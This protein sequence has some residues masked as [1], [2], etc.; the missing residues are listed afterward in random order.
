MKPRLAT[1]AEDPEAGDPMALARAATL[2]SGRAMRGRLWAEAKALAGL[3]ES[4][5]RLGERSTRAVETLE[6]MDLQ[7]LF[8]A[9]FCDVETLQHRFWIRGDDD[10]DHALKS[11]YWAR[12]ADAVRGGRDTHRVLMGRIKLAETAL[13]EAGL[14]VPASRE[15]RMAAFEARR[16]ADLT[17]EAIDEACRGSDPPDGEGD[18][19]TDG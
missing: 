17:D 6:T 15:A 3:A 7:L 5:A 4:Y 12:R 2:A 19:G 1:P 8:D 16:W 18:H 13:A 14:T 9:V 10:P 11:R